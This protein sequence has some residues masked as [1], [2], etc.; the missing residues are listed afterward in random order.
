MLGLKNLYNNTFFG[1]IPKEIH[2]TLKI[3]IERQTGVTDFG[4]EGSS[5][6]SFVQSINLAHDVALKFLADLNDNFTDDQIEDSKVLNSAVESLTRVNCTIQERLS[7]HKQLIEEKAYLNF[8]ECEKQQAMAAEM[9]R[10]ESRKALDREKAGKE[11]LSRD[12]RMEMDRKIAEEESEE[13]EKRHLAT[14]KKIKEEH[15]K[16]RDATKKEGAPKKATVQMA[17]TND[18]DFEKK[19]KRRNRKRGKKK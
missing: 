13:E 12:K 2:D 19:K 15:D 17:K 5:D 1:N 8:L 9:S 6:L 18:D 3:I 7:I 16:R 4:S 11:K 10:Y 14:M